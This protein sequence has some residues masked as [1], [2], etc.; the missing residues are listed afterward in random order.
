MTLHRITPEINLQH[1]HV[2]FFAGVT[3]PPIALWD[4]DGDGL[5]DV[6]IAVTNISN[7]SQ[8][9][10]AQSKGEQIRPL[11]RKNCSIQCKNLYDCNL[12]SYDDKN[13]CN[14]NCR[15]TC[16]NYNGNCNKNYN[17]N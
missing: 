1:Q 17:D 3:S 6:L 4:V 8:P 9:M 7:D 10:S 12:F 2:L 16:N 15:V 13:S 11:K 14:D 5:E